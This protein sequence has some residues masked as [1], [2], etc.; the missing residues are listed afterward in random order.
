MCVSHTPA[1]ETKSAS[2]TQLLILKKGSKGASASHTQVSGPT[3]DSK[4]ASATQGQRNKAGEKGTS[5]TQDGNESKVAQPKEVD[6][7]SGVLS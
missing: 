7:L 5:H 4:E 2:N 3:K 1:S 6:N